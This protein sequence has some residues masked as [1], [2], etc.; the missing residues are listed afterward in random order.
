MPAIHSSIQPI[1]SWDLSPTV[2]PCN[3]HLCL[4]SDL[5]TP[6][7]LEKEGQRPAKPQQLRGG[8]EGAFA[9][10][11]LRCESCA[12]SPQKGSATHPCPCHLSMSEAAEVHGCGSPNAFPSLFTKQFCEE[13]LLPIKALQWVELSPC[14]FVLC[15]LTWQRMR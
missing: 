1:H 9:S 12:F 5:K 10:H 14:S 3:P 2:D 13:S 15:S 4:H 11:R 8:Q 7:H 6:S